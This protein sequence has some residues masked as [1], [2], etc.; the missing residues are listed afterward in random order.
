M[1]IENNTENQIN[2]LLNEALKNKDYNINNMDNNGV[3]VDRQSSTNFDDLK[4]KI[5][6]ST[7]E[8][9][10]LFTENKEQKEPDVVDDLECAASYHLH[11]HQ[12]K[13]NSSRCLMNFSVSTMSNF[14]CLF[15]HLNNNMDIPKDVNI[16]IYAK[17]IL[18]KY[19]EFRKFIHYTLYHTGIPTSVTVMS[20]YLFYILRS[21]LPQYFNKLSSIYK[22]WLVCLLICNKVYLDNSYRNITWAKDLTE[23]PIDEINYLETIVLKAINYNVWISAENFNFWVRQLEWYMDWLHFESISS[24]SI[25]PTYHSVKPS[26][27]DI[28][29]RDEIS[30]QSNSNAMGLDDN[31][32][33]I[34]KQYE[35]VVIPAAKVIQDYNN[36][37]NN[38]IANNTLQKQQQLLQ[39]QRQQLQQQLHQ[40]YNN[41][42]S[43]TSTASTTAIINNNINPVSIGTNQDNRTDYYNMNLSMQNQ[44]DSNNNN[45][46]ESN[47]ILRL[48][49]Q[50]SIN[51]PVS[52]NINGVNESLNQNALLYQQLQQYK[53]NPE[54][55]NHIQIQE[56]QKLLQQG[57]YSNYQQQQQLQQIQQIKQQQQ[58]QLQQQ[59]QKQLQQQLQQQQ[60][61]QQQFQQ[62]QQQQL[63]QQQQQLQQQLQQ[64]IQQQ[65]Q[66]QLQNYNKENIDN[67]NRIH[68]PISKY[69]SN[70]SSLTSTTTSSYSDT[71]TT[72]VSTIVT[73]TMTTLATNV[74]DKIPIVPIGS[75]YTYPL[76]KTMDKYVNND[77]IKTWNEM[78]LNNPSSQSLVPEI[79]GNSI[80]PPQTKHQNVSN[81]ETITKPIE[82]IGSSMNKSSDHLHTNNLSQNRPMYGINKHTNEDQT[83]P[84]ITLNHDNE[85]IKPTETKID[86]LKGSYEDTS[87]V[88][89]KVSSPGES[90]AIDIKKGA[91]INN[92]NIFYYHHHRQPS[93]D[94]EEYK[95][96]FDNLSQISKK[97]LRSSCI[98]S[99]KLSTS[100]RSNNNLEHRRTNTTNENVKLYMDKYY[101]RNKEND[102]K[103]DNTTPLKFEKED[104]SKV[105]PKPERVST[106]KDKIENSELMNGKKVSGNEN[107]KINEQDIHSLVSDS[108]VTLNV[109]DHISESPK[110]SEELMKEINVIQKKYSTRNLHYLVSAARNA[111]KEENSDE[112]KEENLDKEKKDISGADEK[113]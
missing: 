42:H 27:P 13:I 46:S 71:T 78:S 10:K 85:A 96:S 34:S 72:A 44:M 9:I 111:S 104:I 21:K 23:L 24:T 38:Q 95:N 28:Q 88:A 30:N 75:D 33:N 81:H 113:K 20:L 80:I 107:D 101:N 103:N 62:L 60:L 106:L 73:T 18:K 41:Y 56:L 35:N 59:L 22:V 77:L 55:P 37:Q 15:I 102:W 98:N 3:V 64:Q 54:L 67:N 90:K 49:N 86:S 36:Y 82:A 89:S 31:G 63:Q 14:V 93:M 94:G 91:F 48:I 110:Y 69:Y 100:F 25:Y 108:T 47:E 83:I 4:N 43:A 29:E 105:V 11:Y 74:K 26:V 50:L 70:V 32:N 58:Q 92:N 6:T 2:I 19:V 76:N 39:Q 8:I 7:Q 1:I 66:Q 51:K 87:S 17:A 68:V 84:L 97:S 5:K 40:Q 79:N 53:I 45:R 99:I 16:T 61:Q 57:Q 65:L 112:E 109:D 52:N 12:S